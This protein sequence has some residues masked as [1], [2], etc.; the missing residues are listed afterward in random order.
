MY[1]ETCYS[2][3]IISSTTS[4]NLN[5][6]GDRSFRGVDDLIVT[7]IYDSRWRDLQR[8]RLSVNGSTLLLPPSLAIS[9]SSFSAVFRLFGN[10]LFFEQSRLTPGVASHLNLISR[11]SSFPLCHWVMLQPLLRLLRCSRCGLSELRA[12]N[13]FNTA[14]SVARARSSR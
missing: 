6:M 13:K 10:I 8:T 5:E 2:S 11:F 4:I 9:V 7:G 12:Q 14:I 3:V 1:I